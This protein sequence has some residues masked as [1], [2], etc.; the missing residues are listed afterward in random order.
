MRNKIYDIIEIGKDNPRANRT[1]S[2]FMLCC[3]VISLIPLGFKETT[4]FLHLLDKV[5]VTI[6]IIDYLLRL[7]T[8]DIK[9]ESHSITSFVRYPFSPM[10]IIDLLS[11]LPSLALVNR[12]L[13]ALRIA[14]AVR[15]TRALRTVKTVRIVKTMRFSKS[16]SILGKVIRDSKDSLIHLTCIAV[17]YILMTALIIFNVEPQTFSTFFDA[18]YW[19]TVSL[20]TVGYGDIYAVTVVGKLI[21][22]ISSFI[23]IAIVALP[24]GLITAGFVKELDNKE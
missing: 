3:I 5:S 10:A 9:Y 13:K 12:A 21:S 23:G 14:R 1:Y 19:A 24:S 18:L 16:A 6:F 20:T 17:G 7:F 22:M 4:S 11:I 15:L 8:A 2:I